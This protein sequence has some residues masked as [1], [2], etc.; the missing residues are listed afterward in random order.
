[1][2]S[3]GFEEGTTTAMQRLPETP[4]AA[5]VAPGPLPRFQ[6]GSI[7]MQEL[8]RQLAESIANEIMSTEADEVCAGGANSRN[9]YRE[10]RLAT[11]VG[12]PALRVPKPGS[13]SFFPDDVIERYQR[14]DRALVAAVAET[15]ATGTS[16][17][18]VQRVTERLG[19]ARLSKDQAGSIA[20][21]LD[22]DVDEC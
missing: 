18:K 21:S 6:D 7:N 16:T 5:Q 22:A 20:R 9:G 12:T 17:R 14:V 15:C 19:V 3:N 10:R 2:R 13:G 8:V 1:M 11:C 4:I